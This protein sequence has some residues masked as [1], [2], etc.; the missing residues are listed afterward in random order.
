[1]EFIMF[2]VVSIAVIWGVLEYFEV[3]TDSENQND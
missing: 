3:G 1:M 2:F